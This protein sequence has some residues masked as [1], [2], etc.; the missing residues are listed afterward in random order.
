MFCKSKS[1]G[2][3]KEEKGK[4]GKKGKTKDEPVKKQ[5]Q[6]PRGGQRVSDSIQKAK[7][8]ID[9]AAHEVQDLA[10]DDLQ[11][12]K[13]QQHC[14]LHPGDQPSQG[15]QHG[16]GAECYSGGKKCPFLN[17]NCRIKL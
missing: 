8:P 15:S 10:V 17:T 7:P 12:D 14:C 6:K 1:A 9:V 2:S 4:K 5:P 11:D 3:N 16:P 13:V